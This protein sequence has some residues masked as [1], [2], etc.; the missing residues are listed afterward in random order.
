MKNE[1]SFLD[2]LAGAMS[3]YSKE[4]KEEM[5]VEAEDKPKKVKF[6]KKLKKVKKDKDAGARA[7]LQGPSAG[8]L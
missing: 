2:K 3:E 8:T 7:A 5:P 4:S 6:K 1:E